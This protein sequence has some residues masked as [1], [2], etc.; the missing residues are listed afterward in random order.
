MFLKARY[1][2]TPIQS[3]RSSPLNFS[4]LISRKGPL[5]LLTHT[6]TQFFSRCSNVS[7]SG[8]CQCANV[9][10]SGASPSIAVMCPPEQYSV[11][12]SQLHLDSLVNPTSLSSNNLQLLNG[13]RGFYSCECIRVKQQPS[14]HH[15]SSSLETVRITLTHTHIQ[16]NG[17]SALSVGRRVRKSRCSACHG[18]GK[19]GRE[20]E[21]L[22]LRFL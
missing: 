15:I 13:G 14:T 4:L 16:Q 11:S 20:M 21:F 2:S 3:K 8:E 5:G 22:P 7:C 6:S 1:K 17:E 19:G 18:E 10:L 9:V 12:I